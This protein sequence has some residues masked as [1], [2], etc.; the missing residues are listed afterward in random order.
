M[1]WKMRLEADMSIHLLSKYSNNLSHG[2]SRKHG[3]DSKARYVAKS[4]ICHSCGGYDAD[5][6]EADFDL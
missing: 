2:K 1:R 3:T 6:I 4:K 5:G